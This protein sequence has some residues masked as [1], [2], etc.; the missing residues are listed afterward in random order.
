MEWDA[1]R[2]RSAEAEHFFNE[3]DTKNRHYGPTP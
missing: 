1:L 3:Y 2:N